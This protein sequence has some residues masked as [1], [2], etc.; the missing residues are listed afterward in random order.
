MYVMD[1]G[2]HH[3]ENFDNAVRIRA[4][5]PNYKIIRAHQNTWYSKNTAVAM[6]RAVSSRER[7]LTTRQHDMISQAIV[8]IILVGFI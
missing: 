2:L 5:N 1:L 6:T 4:L 3:R 8:A 7:D